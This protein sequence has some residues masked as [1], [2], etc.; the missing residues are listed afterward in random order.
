[1]YKHETKIL[2]PYFQERILQ[3][4]AKWALERNKATPIQ[5]LNNGL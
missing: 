4:V 2:D 3:D 1:M 5:V